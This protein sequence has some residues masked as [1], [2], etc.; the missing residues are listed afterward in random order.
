MADRMHLQVTWDELETFRVSTL[1]V[2][3]RPAP[4]MW[5]CRPTPQ[6]PQRNAGRIA[7]GLASNALRSVRPGNP[8]GYSFEDCRR[9]RDVIAGAINSLTP[10]V[11]A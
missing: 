9:A 4:F 5:R 11:F 10:R 2:F 7:T 6:T 8:D 1:T 3:R